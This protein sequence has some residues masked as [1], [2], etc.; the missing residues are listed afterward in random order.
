VW[1]RGRTPRAFSP[2][3]ISTPPQCARRFT[4][5]LEL[6]APPP[7]L[8]MTPSSTRAAATSWSSR[9]RPGP[10]SQGEEVAGA[11]CRR[12]RAPSRRD[13]LAVGRSPPRRAARHHRRLRAHLSALDRL[14]ASQASLR[15]KSRQKPC[16]LAV[17]RVGSPEFPSRRCSPAGSL[18]TVRRRRA[19]RAARRPISIR[20]SRSHLTSVNSGQPAAQHPSAIPAAGS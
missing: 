10:P 19:V 3:P 7:T 16:L 13:G 9:S 15:C 5:T 17:D 12:P 8:V 14:R 4:Q 11:V 2:P 1:P 6:L 20:R 18:S